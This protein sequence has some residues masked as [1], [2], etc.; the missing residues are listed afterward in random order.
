MLIRIKD[1][2]IN[3]KH[4]SDIGI[5][6]GKNKN[7]VKYYIRFNTTS[8]SAIIVPFDEKEERDKY[9]SRLCALSFNIID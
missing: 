9:Y 8:N 7:V 6:D 2:V 5:Y 1:K 3:L 4:V